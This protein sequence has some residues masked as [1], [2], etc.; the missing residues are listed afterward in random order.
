MPMESLA[1]WKRLNKGEYLIL[2]GSA[3]IVAAL[4]LFGSHVAI[5]T[6]DRA[7]L[8]QYAD[9][10]FVRAVDVAAA[11]TQ[12]LQHTPAIG[13]ACSDADLAN[14]RKI[15]FYSQFLSDVGRLR[16]NRLQCSAVWGRQVSDLPALPP[17]SIEL[18]GFHLWT[19][20]H[21]PANF[22]VMN[23]MAAQGNTLVVT[24]PTAFSRFELLDKSRAAIKITND[25]GTHVFRIFGQANDLP[26][27]PTEA[28][29]QLGS[30]RHMRACD[31]QYLLCVVAAM[32][33]SEL[34]ALHPL[35]L[36]G[37]GL[38]GLLAGAGAGFAVIG[39]R[40][41]YRSLPM[42]LRRSLNRDRLLLHYQPIRAL[43]DRR[44]VGAEALA[45]W[46]DERGVWV[47]PDV[48]IP[49]AERMGLIGQLTRQVVCRALLD[50]GARLRDADGF[51]LS[52]NV[53]SQDLLDRDFH[54]YLHEQVQAAGIQPE[55]IVLEITERSTVEQGE[56]SQNIEALRQH[57]YRF[58]IDDFGTGYSNINTMALLPI[59]A[60]K[61]DKIFIQ[62][63]GTDSPMN[64]II[65]PMCGIAR[66]LDV[67]LVIE[68]IEREEQAVCIHAI[69]P[70][71]LGQG[72]LLGRP[73]PV[74][75]FPA[76]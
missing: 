68:G 64:S 50:M 52:L 60:V 45:R 54:V 32:R 74:A 20:A 21:N 71:A 63:I 29:Y 61:I 58:Y 31:A 56:L 7:Y 66:K 34:F 44:L 6:S 4:V 46:Q 41:R 62:F 37:L 8:R 3:L 69:S 47:P 5:V 53:T 13:E 24:S 25:D 16:D 75:G 67:G 38:L 57:G 43:Q 15:V 11:S 19:N 22:D 49:M 12:V 59:D 76:V 1:S 2:V 33:G 27:A 10:L 70:Q 36:T 14:L 28:W 17:P 72:W 35:L 39:Y 9:Q 51:Y 48:F 65:E 23:D 73:G 40:R 26:F 55:R 30:T 18:N 42:Q